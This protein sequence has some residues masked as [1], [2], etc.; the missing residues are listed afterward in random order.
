M[1]LCFCLAAVNALSIEP[2]PIANTLIHSGSADITATTDAG[3]SY[4]PPSD[5]GLGFADHDQVTHIE[6]AKHS[7]HFIARTLKH[8]LMTV[9]GTSYKMIQDREVHEKLQDLAQNVT[10]QLLGIS[11]DEHDVEQLVKRQSSVELVKAFASQFLKSHI[12]DFESDAED[13]HRQN[14]DI[15]HKF[16][17]MAMEHT[18]DSLGGFSSKLLL[19]PKVQDKFRDLLAE[20]DAT[21][22]SISG[23]MVQR[24]SERRL[25]E[26]LSRRVFNPD[27]LLHLGVFGNNLYKVILL[28]LCFAWIFI[29]FEFLLAIYFKKD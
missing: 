18:L 20:V 19:V 8:T 2:L 12:S 17:L 14:L 7:V 24:T 26:T 13:Y 28:T 9:G 10:M 5:N 11:D 25:Q 6:Q 4:L 1:Q 23:S 3:A 16:T 22:G 29:I 21:L 27:G 15:T